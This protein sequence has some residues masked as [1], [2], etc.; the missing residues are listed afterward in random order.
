MTFLSLFILLFFLYQSLMS[1]LHFRDSM[2]Y[3]TFC[4]W[5]ISFNMASPISSHFDANDMI[6]FL[7]SRMRF[8]CICVCMCASIHPV[9]DLVNFLFQPLWAVVLTIHMAEQV[10]LK[11]RFMCFSYIL[12]SEIVISYSKSVSR[13]PPR[14]FLYISANIVSY[15]LNN[16]LYGRGNTR[17]WF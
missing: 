16:S 14:T 1:S 4:V 11:Q 6:S 10:S 9:M 13:F 3:L 5:I 15:F 7:S 8:H 17:S 2:Q 12:R